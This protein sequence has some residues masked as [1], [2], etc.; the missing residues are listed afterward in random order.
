MKRVN[1]SWRLAGESAPRDGFATFDDVKV[2]GTRLAVSVKFNLHAVFKTHSDFNT[3]ITELPDLSYLSQQTVLLSQE[4]FM[5][6]G[7]SSGHHTSDPE[8]SR[9]HVHDH[10]Y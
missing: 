8:R 1:V 4:E 6:T 3:F 7:A 2:C 5:G 10:V 9:P